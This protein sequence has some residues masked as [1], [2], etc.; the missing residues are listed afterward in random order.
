MRVFLHGISALQWWTRARTRGESSGAKGL[1]VEALRE[2]VPSARVVRYLAE[3][4]PFLERPYH[5]LVASSSER[6]AV[7][8][9]VV[10]RC[11]Y[12]FPEGSFVRVADGVY[13]PCPEL[14]FVQIAGCTPLLPAIKEGHALCGSF[15]LCDSSET[16]LVERLPLTT[17][18]SLRR[19]AK[20]NSGLRGSAAAI[21]TLRHVKDGSASPRETDLAMRL[22]LPVRL[23]GFGLDGA[24]LNCRIDP[25]KRA[26]LLADV[27]YFVGDLCWPSAKLVIEYD[28]NLHLSPRQ[29]ARD[30]RKRSAL[31]ADGY[32]VITVTSP[33]LDDPSEMMRVALRA[34]QR[35]GKRLRIQVDDFADRQKKLFLLSG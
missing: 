19:F 17:V 22:M 21:R 13:A 5:V 2:C 8:H 7:S 20:E 14:C 35:L 34:A 26:G 25:S 16:G 10:H 4:F 9:A 33:Q 11:G 23:G 30:A 32:A 28:S 29:L 12:P 27:S 18:D 1:G 31:E 6:R 15:A 3:I 24:V